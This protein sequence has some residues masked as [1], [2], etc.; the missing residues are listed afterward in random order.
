VFRT[1]KIQSDFTTLDIEKIL[2]GRKYLQRM[3]AF[4]Q[5]RP[6]KKAKSSL[7]A[8]TLVGQNERLFFPK[9][10]KRVEN[11]SGQVFHF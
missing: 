2:Q 6:L 7:L 11:L 4:C 1:Q 9:G 8:V 5:R 3:F 10:K